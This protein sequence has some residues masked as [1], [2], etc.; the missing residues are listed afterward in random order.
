[1]THSL[2]RQGC[3][4]SLKEDFVVLALG[5]HKSLAKKGEESLMRK[6]PRM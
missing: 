2:H 3:V 6:H 4:D 5:G 1:M